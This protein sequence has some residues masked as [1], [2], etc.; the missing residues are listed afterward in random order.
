ME[1]LKV[2]VLFGGDSSEAEVSR[3]SAAQV[4]DCL[5]RTLFDPVLVS[6][7]SGGWTTVPDGLVV[8]KNDFSAGGE[9]LDYALIVIHGTPGE[10]GILQGY[11]D[12]VGV[13]YSSCSVGV[14]ALTFNKSLCKLSLH[15]M[16]EMQFSK[17]IVVNRG[18][19]IDPRKIVQRLGLPLFVKPNASGSSCGVSKVKREQEIQGA[20][21]AAFKEGDTVLL[22]EYIEGV[23]VSQGVMICDKEIF[24]LPITELVSK[25]E[26][27][28]YQAKYTVGMTQE[29]TPARISAVVAHKISTAT[30]AAYQSLGCRGIVRIDY[31]IKDEKPYFIEVNTVPG[32]SAESIV[33]QQWAYIGMTMGE[34][35]TKIINSTNTIKNR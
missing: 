4:F 2:A 32:M 30:L 21:Q 23:E 7:S 29:I 9:K 28:D 25:N 17:E 26:F 3:R 10:N 15:G 5:D 18:E 34:A 8:D 11:L 19:K 33:P 22:E 1:R 24:V 13:P 14:S 27:F 16:P 31:I 35:Y 6:L 20:I 12:L